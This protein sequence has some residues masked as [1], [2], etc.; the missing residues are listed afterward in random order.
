MSR[1]RPAELRLPALGCFGAADAYRPN[2][3]QGPV[4][5]IKVDRSFVSQIDTSPHRRVPAE[6]A[7]LR[8]FEPPQLRGVLP[9]RRG[10]RL[11]CDEAHGYRA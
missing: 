6:P 7:V 5:V 2:L 8:V 9:V 11:A 10:T 1:A 4:D 3:R